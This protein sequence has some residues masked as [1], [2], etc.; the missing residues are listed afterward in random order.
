ARFTVNGRPADPYGLTRLKKGD[1]VE[2]DTAGG[3]GFGDPAERDTTAVAR[4]I[5]SGRVTPER[6]ELD[7]RFA[8]ETGVARA[9]GVDKAR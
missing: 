2:F 3:G 7:Y 4:D 9:G 5:A 1:L 8:P 6:V